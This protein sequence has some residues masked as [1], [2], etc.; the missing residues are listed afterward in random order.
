MGAVEEI[1][2]MAAPALASA[3]LELW[4][5]E[6]SRDVV[7][8]LVDRP[9]GG[10]D[11][12]TLTA[13]SGVIGPLLDE[14]PELAPPGRYQL[15][16]SSPGLER[17]LR[18]PAQY[19]RY[20]GAEVAVKTS[21]P[22]AGSRRHRG[23]LLEAGEKSVRILPDGTA[24]EAEVEFSYEQIDRAR[25]VLVWGP[26]AAQAGSRHAPRSPS[27]GRGRGRAIAAPLDHPAAGPN[28]E[29]RRNP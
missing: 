20:V 29:G 13:A 15:E 11:L 23:R 18:T 8:F 21:V 27:R 9:A 6:V 17:T 14:R 22:V 26:H 5:V 1:R 7:R 28:P 12:D 10:V 19:S 16:V 24:G 2:E 4:D 25:T 3:G